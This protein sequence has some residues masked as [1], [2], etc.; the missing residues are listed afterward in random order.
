M[1]AS[2]RSPIWPTR[3]FVSSTRHRRPDRSC[4]VR[5]KAHALPAP[6]HPILR[7]LREGRRRS[8]SR[9]G[10]ILS[11]RAAVVPRRER[12][13]D[14]RYPASSTHA[15]VLQLG[16]HV[17]PELGRFPYPGGAGRG[18]AR[19]GALQVAPRSRRR[20]AAE[21]VHTRFAAHPGR[22]DSHHGRRAALTSS[23]IAACST[24]ASV[25][26]FVTVFSE[27]MP[28]SPSVITTL[29]RHCRWPSLPDGFPFG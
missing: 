26:D 17:H 16:E 20:P 12:V 13:S 25:W 2:S 8:S 6:R 14:N 22:S 21:A 24:S 18:R 23:R 19:R 5:D 3:R 27:L 15:L 7:T 28:A 4:R 1:V 29:P 9:P 11:I 10:H